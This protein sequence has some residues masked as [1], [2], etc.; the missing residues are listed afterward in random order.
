VFADARAGRA[1]AA[2]L[3][4]FAAGD[5]P[6]YATAL[7]FDPGSTARDSDL[8]GLIFADTP[9]LIAPDDTAN[10]VRSE[11]L[12]NWPQ[13][14]GLLRFYG[15]GFDAYR[16]VAPLYGDD[17]AAWPV[18]GLSGDLSL[19]AA[20]RVHRVLP[21]AQFRSGRPVAFE[22]ADPRAIDSS[23]IGSR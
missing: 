13:R 12:E 10:A 4:F 22:A 15:M 14:A 16:L 17:N 1:L 2:Q 23:L 19:D 8:N 20:G 7:I 18:R 9:V 5:I 6:T 3:R 11:L 21:L